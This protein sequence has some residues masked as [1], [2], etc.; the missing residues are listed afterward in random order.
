MSARM[1][2]KVMFGTAGFDIAD[3]N[4]GLSKQGITFTTLIRNV[5]LERGVGDD[6]AQQFAFLL[7]Q[8]ENLIELNKNQRSTRFDEI[9]DYYVKQ[10]A[11]RI[12]QNSR[13][14]NF[15]YKRSDRPKIKTLDPEKY[16]GTP[17]APP[18][19]LE[20]P[21]RDGWLGLLDDIVP[22]WDGCEPRRTDLINFNSLKELVDERNQSLP[23]D[24]RLESDPLCINEAP[25][26][27]I[28]D[29]FSFAS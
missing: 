5:L 24:P 3:K 17:E 15:G 23:E 20:P 12:S 28:L 25:Y 4:K 19:Y 29:K 9:S 14:F 18:F 22:E 16:G 8:N 11:N 2:K 21:K 10:I 26:D 6:A 1:W 27:K 7:R 13:A